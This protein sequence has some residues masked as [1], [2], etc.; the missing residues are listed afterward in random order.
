ML[1]DACRVTVDSSS[2]RVRGSGDAL[3]AIAR[4][5][6]MPKTALVLFS[7]FSGEEAS[8]GS[9]DHS[10]FAQVVL[11]YLPNQLSMGEFVYKVSAKLGKSRQRPHSSGCLVDSPMAPP[12]AVCRARESEDT[13]QGRH[14]T[15]AGGG[16][17]G[18]GG[19]GQAA[20]ASD[21]AGA[22]RAGGG[23][24]RLKNG[25]PDGSAP[26]RWKAGGGPGAPEIVVSGRLA[27]SGTQ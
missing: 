12:C 10:P 4:N 11:E 5:L 17:G 20:A 8:D 27:R 7:C 21:G 18:G 13:G 26:K 2:R 22:E 16:G 15:A 23:G 14:S 25:E 6:E 19:S 1:V 3:E 24:K 9:G